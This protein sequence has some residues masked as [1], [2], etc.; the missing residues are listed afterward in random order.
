M[1]LNGEGPVTAT[2]GCSGEW[3]EG[4]LM[5]VS[6]HS[7]WPVPVPAEHRFPECANLPLKVLTIFAK[8][9]HHELGVRMPSPGNHVGLHRL[10]EKA[11]HP[12]TA[13]CR[14]TENPA[15]PLTPPAS[16][17]PQ[18]RQPQQSP[19]FSPTTPSPSAAPGAKPHQ[20]TAAAT[21]TPN[22]A[23]PSRTSAGCLKRFVWNVFRPG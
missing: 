13:A 8:V 1:R 3:R 19:V 11:R 6:R 10:R 9:P 2:S 5:V 20:T 17:N 22:R 12:Q 18:R 15:S 4:R 14:N 7:Q 16:P 21:T 23:F